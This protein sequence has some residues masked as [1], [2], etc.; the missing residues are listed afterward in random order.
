MMK[1][2]YKKLS[3]TAVILLVLTSVGLAQE[4]VVSGTVTDENGGSMPGVNVLVKGTS[5]G[6]ATDSDGNFKVSVSGGDQSTLVFTFVGY[7]TAE[8]VVGARSV[9]NIQ[10]TPDVQ[11]LTELVVTGYS[12]QRKADITGAVAVV[13]AESL[14]A[15]KGA[16]VGQQL[17]GRA[18]GV[19]VSTSG[20]PGAE[21]NIR[22]RGISSL[23]G[24]SD[25]L[26]IIDG[27]QIQ[28][29]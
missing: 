2:L 8:I 15:I 14:K 11:T 16:N 28:G 17:A 9:V 27:V 22:I 6:T 29:D 21:S 3:L 13:D 20:G 7:A 24:S 5:S 26:F 4:R 1:K 23:T 25:P 10:L 18:P 19:T 12:S